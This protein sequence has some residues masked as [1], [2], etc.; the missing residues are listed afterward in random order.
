MS[1]LC[2]GG[3]EKRG[4]KEGGGGEGVGDFELNS[5]LTS[6]ASNLLLFFI[7]SLDSQT[8][9]LN[10]QINHSSELHHLQSLSNHQTHFKRSASILNYSSSPT[11]PVRALFSPLFCQV[12]QASFQSSLFPPLNSLFQSCFCEFPYFV[13]PLSTLVQ[14]FSPHP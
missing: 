6:S 2:R 7:A 9:D 4:K 3:K 8:R 14:C 5:K 12:M 10:F 11:C 13:N 1:H